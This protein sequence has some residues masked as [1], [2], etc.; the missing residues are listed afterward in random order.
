MPPF[1][2]ANTAADEDEYSDGIDAVNDT[3]AAAVPVA[4]VDAVLMRS[5]WSV[6]CSKTMGVT[7][8]R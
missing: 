8:R 2:F 1:S 3:C 4:A 7:N 5:R 6:R